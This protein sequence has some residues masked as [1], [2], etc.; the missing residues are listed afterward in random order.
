MTYFGYKAP[1]QDKSVIDWAG[2]TKTI[3]D[4]L[5]AEK[6]RRDDTKVFL[7]QENAKQLQK[8][9]EYEQGLDP[10]ANT[11]MIEQIQSARDFLMEN[12]RLMKRGIRGVND[13]RLVSQNV[14]NTYTDL[15]NA[16]K[17][18]NSKIEA[19]SKL[20]GKSNEA[21]IDE[22]ANFAQLRNRR[23]HNDPNTGAG[24]LVDVDPATGEINEKT[25]MPV[26]AINSIQQQSFNTVNVTDEVNKAV[27]K[28]GTWKVA[29]SSTS[30][31]SNV[32]LN[33]KYQ[34]TIDD[35]SR[36]ILSSDEKKASVLL[37]Y[38]DLEYS[39]DADD[40]AQGTI[41]YDFITGYDEQ[42]KPTIEERELNI[43]KVLME[44]GPDGKLKHTLTKE[45]EDLALE[46]IKS[47]IET[48]L[49]FETSKDKPTATD[50]SEGKARQNKID[51]YN[52]VERFFQGSSEAG[53][54]LAQ[55]FG[56]DSAPIIEGDK[57]VYT[58]GGKEYTSDASGNVK[59]A[60]STFI[61][62]LANATGG[63]YGMSVEDYGRWSTNT[64]VVPT[65]FGTVATS[66]K[67][68]TAVENYVTP[69]NVQAI[70]KS[71]VT[72][73]TDKDNQPVVIP[74]EQQKVNAIKSLQQLG[75]GKFEVSPGPTD[76]IK[77]ERDG[78]MEFVTVRQLQENPE[79]VLQKM[80]GLVRKPSSSGAGRFNP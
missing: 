64:S 73:Y 41:T 74:P 62:G 11:W 12:H 7:D 42:G 52:T 50:I 16:L 5:L 38:L 26:R 9:N 28:M 58:I 33:P 18:Y 76:S 1:D 31:I 30:D 32:R 47:N 55:Q 72:Q 77:I 34:Q 75:A 37:D 29:L 19:L 27:E 61:G 17:T 10:Q 43:G 35:L 3:S 14:M 49:L 56:M 21:L 48:K 51:T 63:K 15:N 67:P 59:D 46:A 13:K 44:R 70:Q 8:I 66:L 23:I 6:K 53:Q 40:A 45:Q 39:R 2:L 80:Q 57:M 68:V 69:K 60:S 25:L 79:A 54:S 36:S 65:N 20:P 4:N 71:V 22:M 78:R 24:Y